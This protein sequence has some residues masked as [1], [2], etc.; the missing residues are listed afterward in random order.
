MTATPSSPYDRLKMG[1]KAADPFSQQVIEGARHA[2]SGDG[3]PL[4]FTFFAISMR[5]LFE[6][7]MDT[8]APRC[9]VQTCAWFETENRGWPAYS[10]PAHHLCDPGR[11]Y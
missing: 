8:L 6:H 7:L 1:T 4:R 9:K 2:L 5:I 11:L 3:N 10:P